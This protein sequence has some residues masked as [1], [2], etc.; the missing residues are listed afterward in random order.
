MKEVGTFPVTGVVGRT[1]RVGRTGQAL[2]SSRHC[3]PARARKH[4]NWR[5]C[6]SKA[7][8]RNEPFAEAGTCQFNRRSDTDS[9]L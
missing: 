9:Q 7:S 3:G 1:S 6:R 8:V 2:A 5:K 4:A